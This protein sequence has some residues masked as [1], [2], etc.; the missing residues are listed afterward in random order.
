MFEEEC[1]TE[2]V[3]C[4]HNAVKDE[5]LIAQKVYDS[6]RRQNCLTVNEIGPALSAE[7]ID[8]PDLKVS[9]G[10]R[11]VP[12]KN[13][14]SVTM[15]KVNVSA[16]KVVDKQPSPFKT[17]YW[18]VDVKYDM[19]YKLTFRTSCGKV[20]ECP[21]M[22][23][24]T[25]KTTLFGSNNNEIAIATD[26]YGDSGKPV[27]TGSPFTW[28]EAKCMGLEARIAQG[29]HEKEVHVIIG[30]FSI[31]KLFRLVH[32]NVQSKGFCIPKECIDQG[33]VNPCKYFDD[34]DFPMD[35]FVPPQKKEFHAGV[36]ENIRK[37]S[38]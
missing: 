11:I 16:I 25:V 2:E 10:H 24:F 27:L 23:V 37:T 17:G 29:A 30:L 35:I 38:V 14:V 22:S 32:L 20:T 13:A 21:A 31:I 7:D 5:C 36:S 19:T 6:C 4:G 1:I 34:L 12:P 15:D 3:S 28:V 18:D 9:A 8:H 33:K 26:M